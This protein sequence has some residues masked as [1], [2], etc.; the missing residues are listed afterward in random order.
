MIEKNSKVDTE[1]YLKDLDEEYPLGIGSVDDTIGPILFLLSEQ[2]KWIT[3]TEI[4]VDGG[5]SL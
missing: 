5:A 2:S 1:K 3:G 4:I